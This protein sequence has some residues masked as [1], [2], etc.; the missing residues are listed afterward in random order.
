MKSLASEPGLRKQGLI[1][2]N[3]SIRVEF[4]AVVLFSHLYSLKLSVPCVITCNSA[5]FSALWLLCGARRL[6]STP[7]ASFRN[8]RS[9][10]ETSKFSIALIR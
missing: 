2:L 9:F 4:L 7:L 8:Q 10:L 3:V 6:G 5:Q 1:S